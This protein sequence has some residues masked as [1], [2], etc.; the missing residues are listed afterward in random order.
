MNSSSAASGEDGKASS[1]SSVETY[2]SSEV[3][4]E[5]MGSMVLSEKP[6]KKTTKT[7]SKMLEQEV[8]SNMLS[9]C[10][11]DSIAKQLEDVVLEEKRGSK[12]KKASNES[13]RAQKSKSRKRPGASDGH[14]VDFT[15]T[16]IIGD[17]STNMEQGAMNQYNYLSNSI[18]VDNYASSQS[19][20]KDS[21]QDYTERLYKEFNEILS[22]GK[23][24]ASDEKM[25]PAL[26][27]S[28]KAPGSKSGVQSVKW[29]DANGSDL[30]T[31]KLYENS[32][33][34]VKQSE[35]AIDISLR[36]E[37]AEACAAAL[38]EAA[39]AVCSGTSEVDDAGEH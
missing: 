9:S 32:S 36:R 29:A 30:E 26:K 14:E 4:A 8:D 28:M 38:A 13:S 35:E 15:S 6:I 3:I 18:L 12:K 37:S 20:A 39:E 22:I 27:S 34:N 1:S 16:I 17:A 7:P 33:S 25:K 11:S 31:S 19:A 10:I 21:P 23:D 5:K 2:I 24:E